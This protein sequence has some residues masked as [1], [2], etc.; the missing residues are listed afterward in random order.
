MGTLQSALDVRFGPR[1]VGTGDSQQ[2]EQ[3]RSPPAPAGLGLG[4]FVR[5]DCPDIPFLK[6]Q[7]YVFVFRMFNQE[8]CD[9]V[10]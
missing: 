1:L 5:P 2:L 4:D 3:V 8:Q 9:V 6:G 7:T 10:R